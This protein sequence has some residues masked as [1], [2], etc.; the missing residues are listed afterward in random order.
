[1]STNTRVQLSAMMFLQFFVWGAW[2]VTMG[3]YLT[4]TLKATGVQTGAAYSAN[5]IATIVSPFIVGLIADR[6]FA[7]QKFM[8]VLHLLGAALLYFATTVTDPNAFFWIIL[9]YS[10][11]YMPTL[12]LSNTVAFNL[13]SEPDK[14]FPRIRVFGTLGWIVVGLIIGALHL[15]GVANLAA[16]AI[17]F[18]IAAGASLLLGLYSFTLPNT[19]PKAANTEGASIGQILG[20]DALVLFKDSS[21]LI[22]FISSILVCIP[23]S[24]YYSFTNPFL[25]QV[26]MENATG[27]MTMGQISEVLFMVLLP[28][29][30]KRLGI[31]NIL[32]VAMLAWM[33]RFVSF[34]FGNADSM[35]ALLYLGIILHGV[36]YD[37]FFVSGMIYTET[38]AGPTIKSAAQGLITF[39]TYGVGM[40]I[41]TYL[42]GLVKD[43]YTIND[44]TAWQSFWLVPAGITLAVLVFLFLFFREKEEA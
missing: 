40:F 20:L 19:P 33:L 4:E 5:A 37:F 26:G 18:K 9:L 8:G 27:K 2:Y 23:L 17:P 13:M 15:E 39:A 41:G 44:T 43:A 42:S 31:K 25:T 21:Y 12:A 29:F 22:F 28:L 34:S 24:F 7:A 38:K 14:E 6:Y 11:A 3:T 32:V 30:Y 35:L 10:A 1:M 36:C 16:T